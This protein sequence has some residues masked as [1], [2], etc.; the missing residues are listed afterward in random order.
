MNYFNLICIIALLSSVM[1]FCNNNNRLDIKYTN[2]YYAVNLVDQTPVYVKPDDS[3]YPIYYIENNRI[4]KMTA[5]ISMKNSKEIWYYIKEPDFKGYAKMNNFK[6]FDDQKKAGL[7]MLDKHP[8]K[9]GIPE[10]SIYLQGKSAYEKGD[11]ENSINKL[12]QLITL[13]KPLKQ[14]YPII[15]Y[16]TSILIAKI[17]IKMKEYQRAISHLKELLS[18]T[19]K[20]ITL[21][22]SYFNPNKI[23]F[24]IKEIN[25]YR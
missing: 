13:R 4:V 21:P 2:P 6:L 1:S 12:L 23:S 9:K 16:S 8:S 15:Y 3:I 14:S 24:N 20:E 5:S 18:Q 7:F 17:Y 11:Y 19:P 10:L 22:G 25:K